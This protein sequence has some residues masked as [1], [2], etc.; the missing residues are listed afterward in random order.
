MNYAT[1]P[2]NRFEVLQRIELEEALTPNDPRNVDTTVARGNEVMLQGLAAKFGV[3]LSP[4]SFYPPKKR[5]VLFFGHIGSGKSTE[6]RRYAEKL[7]GADKFYVVQIDVSIELDRNNLQYA[8]VLMALAK[9]LLLRLHDDQIAFARDKLA[10]LERWFTEQV[11]TEERRKELSMAIEAGAQVGGGVPGLISLFSKFT[12][13]FKT[14]TTYKEAF[15]TVVRNGFTQFASAFNR[16]LGD[17]EHA[18]VQAARGRRVL[19]IIDGTDKLSGDDSRRFFVTDATQLLEIEALVVYT[20]PLS[21]KYEG[22][23]PQLLDS[24]LVLPLL[25]LSD[26]DGNPYPPGMAAMSDMLLRRAARSL[27]ADDAVVAQLV[28]ASGGHPREL[29]RLLKLSCELMS[30]NTIDGAVVEKAIAKL[31]GEFRRWLEADDYA[32]LVTE[33]RNRKVL[34]TQPR[35]HKL[36]NN[37]ALLEYNDGSWRRPHPAVR[38]LEGF[39]RADSAASPAE[40]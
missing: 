24:D 29:L 13:A 22:A 8:D 27:F 16:F 40:S 14:N 18:L 39:L 6:L 15:R 20:A 31:A 11:L 9:A 1:P 4:F 30:G 37:L 3:G 19:F 38:T 26:I 28:T 33:Y 35:A 21:M 23:I 2:T 10:P 34:D 7:A 12:S 32:L 25:K 5:H 17:A 36:L